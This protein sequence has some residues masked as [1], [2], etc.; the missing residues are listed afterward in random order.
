MYF[1]DHNPPHFHAIYGGKE[2]QIGIDKVQLIERE[3]PSRA[4]SMVREWAVL[5]RK[6]ASAE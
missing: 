5:H 1:D 3:L 2:A 6:L 4:Q